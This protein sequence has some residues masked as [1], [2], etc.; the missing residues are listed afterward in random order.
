VAWTWLTPD[1]AG[2]RFTLNGADYDLAGGRLFLVSTKGREVRVRQL[3]R[4]LSKVR[5][6]SLQ[7]FADSDPDVTRF[8]AQLAS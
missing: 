2:G 4:D 1:N 8:I 7:L 6:E 3:Q 5:P